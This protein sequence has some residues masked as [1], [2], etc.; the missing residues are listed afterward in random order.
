MRYGLDLPRL[1]RER[2]CV[3]NRA[4]KDAGDKDGFQHPNE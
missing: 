3:E 4:K 2:C 1:E